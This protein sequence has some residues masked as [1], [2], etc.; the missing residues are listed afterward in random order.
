[1][2]KISCS[3]LLLAVVKSSSRQPGSFS[4]PVENLDGKSACEFL[5]TSC[6]KDLH[7]II[8]VVSQPEFTLCSLVIF[9]LWKLYS[10]PDF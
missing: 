2:L 10:F 5:L 9:E 3:N 6:E 1:M 4:V 7:K 8:F